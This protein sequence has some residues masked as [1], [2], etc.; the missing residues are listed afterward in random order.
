M[1]SLF[2]EVFADPFQQKKNI[3]ILSKSSQMVVNS[4]K[5]K[6][7]SY[8]CIIDIWIK[9]LINLCHLLVFQLAFCYPNKKSFSCFMITMYL[10]FIK[11]CYFKIH[12][13]ANKCGLRTISP[14]SILNCCIIQIWFPAQM[15]LQLILRTFCWFKLS[16]KYCI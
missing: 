4:Q 6:K 1:Y 15:Y 7:K 16:R 12:S 11:W 3:I 9:C 10:S 8:E 2:Y 14:Y 13:S 5:E